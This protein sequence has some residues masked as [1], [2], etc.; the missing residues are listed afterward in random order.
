MPIITSLGANS[1]LPGLIDA[2]G[3]YAEEIY[4]SSKIET[5]YK[6]L[7]GVYKKWNLCREIITLQNFV[8][9]DIREPTCAI[10]LIEPITQAV[11]PCGHT[12]CSN[13]SK[14]LHMSCGICRGLVRERIR[15]YFS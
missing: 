12:F 13:C 6:D 9:E 4:N 15:L 5:T 1:A 3:K 11:I 10:C 14:K 7:V 8:K 2:F